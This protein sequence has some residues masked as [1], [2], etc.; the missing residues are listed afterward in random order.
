MNAVLEDFETAPID[1]KLRATL[2]FLQKVTLHPEQVA[3]A[4]AA[5]VRAAGVSEE[6]LV[7]ALYVCFAFNLIDRLADSFHF[8]VPPAE[9]FAAAAPLMLKRGYDI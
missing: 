4:D 9:A 7:D 2:R 6:A 1:D 5:A 3:L 8:E